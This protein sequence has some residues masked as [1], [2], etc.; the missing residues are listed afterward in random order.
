MMDATTHEMLVEILDRARRTETRLT[1]YIEAQGMETR[2]RRPLFRDG[3]LIVPSP[4]IALNE[5]TS[6]V[7]TW[8]KGITPVVFKDQVIARLFLGVG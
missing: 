7:P 8:V 5:C 1:A 4:A 6:S 2:V 3:C